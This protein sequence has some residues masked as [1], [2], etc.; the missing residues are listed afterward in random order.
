MHYSIVQ[1]IFYSSHFSWSIVTI[2]TKRS[3]VIIIKRDHNF[4]ATRS[5][6]LLFS[7]N[8]TVPYIEI[9]HLVILLH[10]L[11]YSKRS[12]LTEHVYSLSSRL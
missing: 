2:F 11:D 8:G 3:G 9:I 10:N 1:G 6:V 4:R 5:K 7:I 12:D